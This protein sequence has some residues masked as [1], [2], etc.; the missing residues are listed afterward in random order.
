MRFWEGR[1]VSDISRALGV[2]QK[3]LYRRLERALVQVRRALEADGLSREVVMS[4]LRDES[5]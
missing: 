1:C 5:Q 4:F 2:P 3:R